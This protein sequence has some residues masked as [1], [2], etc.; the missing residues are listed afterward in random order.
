MQQG[1]QQGQMGGP[2]QGQ[3]GGPQQQMNH[4]GQ[5]RPNMPNQIGQ[6]RGPGMPVTMGSPPMGQRMPTLANQMFTP[7][8]LPV[9]SGANEMLRKQLEQP[10]M[11]RPTNSHLAAQLT[12]QNSGGQ[13]VVTSTAGGGGPGQPSLLLSQLAKQTTTDPNLDVIKQVA[14]CHASKVPN[15]SLQPVMPKPGQPGLVKQELDIKQ[16]NEIKTEIKEEP[17]DSSNVNT[18]TAMDIKVNYFLGN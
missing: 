11:I 16:E 6:I 7:S 4:A 17:M 2:Q 12:G 8:D 13:Q 14:T 1:P 15:D 3:M 10:G 5:P 18:S 9:S